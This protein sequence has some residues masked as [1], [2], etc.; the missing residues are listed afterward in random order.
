[1][2]TTSA[3]S[4][5]TSA[6]RIPIRELAVDGAEKDVAIDPFDKWG[7]RDAGRVGAGEHLAIHHL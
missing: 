5:G 3:A 2:F 4:L 1:M 7:A 6:K